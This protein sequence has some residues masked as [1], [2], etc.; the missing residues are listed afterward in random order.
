M[1]NCV[2]TIYMEEGLKSLWKGI[3]AG[4]Q[5]QMVFAGIRIGTY[6]AV[7][8]KICG[9]LKEGE[10]PKFH[11]RVLAALLTG[12]IGITIACPTDVVKI[13]LQAE[14]RKP[15]GEPMKY[16]GSIDAYQKIIKNEGYVIN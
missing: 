4:I 15:P 1:V 7:R 10:Q 3:F 12:A 6:P 11:H 9:E 14:G 13:R 2:K 8:D 5:R 16:N